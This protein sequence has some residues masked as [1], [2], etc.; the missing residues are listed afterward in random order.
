MK[1]IPVFRV[2]RPYLDLLVKPR[3][4]LDFLEKYDFNFMHLKGEMTFILHKIIFFPEK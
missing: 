2:T 1:K 4:I 3:I